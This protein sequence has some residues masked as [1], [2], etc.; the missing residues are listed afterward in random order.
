MN[1]MSGINAHSALSGLHTFFFGKT[2]GDALGFHLL[3]LWGRDR[4]G[5]VE[6]NV[7][8]VCR[9]LGEGG[10]AEASELEAAFKV[11]LEGLGYGE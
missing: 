7:Q 6:L 8:R 9:C 11:N 1:A 3:P 4:R 10:F 5:C 2:Q